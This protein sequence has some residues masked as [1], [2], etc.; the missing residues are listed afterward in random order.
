M[1]NSNQHRKHISVI[2][3][4]VALSSSSSNP[5]AKYL[6]LMETMIAL[7]GT[8][9][10]NSSLVFLIELANICMCYIAKYYLVGT[11]VIILTKQSNFDYILIEC[12]RFTNLGPIISVFWLD[13]VL[14]SKLRLDVIVYLVDCENIKMD[15]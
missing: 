8:D 6:L 9:F 1:L 2:K 10:K 11:L 12:S 4:K 5:E 14:V 7:D 3:N 13:N 15:L